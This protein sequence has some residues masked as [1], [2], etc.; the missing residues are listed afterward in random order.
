MRRQNFDGGIQCTGLKSSRTRK[1]MRCSRVPKSRIRDRSA[2]CF[3][4]VH[5][6][7]HAH[8]YIR[9][10]L[11]AFQ[12]H[13]FYILTDVCIANCWSKMNSKPQIVPTL[14]VEKQLVVGQKV[15]VVIICFLFPRTLRNMKWMKSDVNKEFQSN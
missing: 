9:L 12:E 4:A 2:Q 1:I 14:I 5:F 3:G 8:V 13:K 7:E 11:W 10:I 6:Y 15:R